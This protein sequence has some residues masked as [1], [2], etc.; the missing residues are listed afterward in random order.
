MTP[1]QW[2]PAEAFQH[3]QQTFNHAAKHWPDVMERYIVLLAEELDQS[4]Q[5]QIMRMALRDT[6]AQRYGERT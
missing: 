5:T 4:Q 3:L 6:V 2:T 1:S